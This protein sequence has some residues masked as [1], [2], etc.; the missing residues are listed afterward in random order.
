MVKHL[1]YSG[2]D[3]GRLGPNGKT[4]TVLW[5]RYRKVRSKEQNNKSRDFNGTKQK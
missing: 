1:L 5:I 3:T 2:S 4:F